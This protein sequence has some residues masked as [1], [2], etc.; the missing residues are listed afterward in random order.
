MRVSGLRKGSEASVVAV[1]SFARKNRSLRMT[2]RW[3]ETLAQDDRV[4]E[5][6][7]DALC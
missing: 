6:Y 5:M 3:Q 7:A 4:L 1:R 2:S